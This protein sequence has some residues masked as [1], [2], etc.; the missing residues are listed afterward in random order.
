MDNDYTKYTA[1]RLLNDDCFLLS[2]KHPTQESKA[3]WTAIQAEHDDLAKEIIIAR[4]FLRHVKNEGNDKK[5]PAEAGR[6][7]WTRIEKE[8]RHYDRRYMRAFLKIAGVAAAV[9][10]LLAAGWQVWFA[11][12]DDAE[13]DYI[14]ML[15]AMEPA[16][17]A[18]GSVQLIFDNDRT[19]AVDGEETHIEYLNEGAVQINAGEKVAVADETD[20]AKALNQLVVPIG[21]RST[22]ILTDGTKVWINSGSKVI[23]P[24]R[25]A[26]DKREIFAEGEIYL[27]V[28]PDADRP[29][30]V[31]TARMEVKALGTEFNV[32]AYKD[33]A[34][35]SVVL[36]SGKVE[37]RR[38][39]AG[40]STLSPSQMFV[41]NRQT[42]ADA[43]STVDAAD[44]IA[45]KD[46][47]Y[48][49]HRQQLSAVLYKLSKYYGVRFEWDEQIDTLLC[50]G[51][52][53]L[54]DQLA[55]V[56][57]MLAKAAPI[58]V[59]E[60]SSHIYISIKP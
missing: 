45:W 44:Y 49:F 59:E 11:A 26:G 33:D 39:G 8:N 9:A 57:E 5:L 58:K 50:S 55:E 18:S 29:F 54:K 46:G 6:K 28:S 24:V 12:N 31:K 40:K 14:A 36:V 23:Y 38:S 21:K 60:N 13:I 47:Y 41:H 43:I 27:E 25:F 48:P 51:K 1:D 34:D 35:L 52:L 53:D 2:E 37:I 20:R 32:S 30:V 10:V 7:L 22:L 56:L 19:I 17:N 4:A 3:F 16:Q 15:D 42:H